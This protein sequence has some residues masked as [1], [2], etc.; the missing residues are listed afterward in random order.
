MIL[1]WFTS[2]LGNFMKCKDFGFNHNQPKNGWFGG[3]SIPKLPEWDF[4]SKTNVRISKDPTNRLWVLSW[5]FSWFEL[6]SGHS[7]TFIFMDWVYGFFGEHVLNS[8]PK[9][10]NRY[11][12][13]NKSGANNII[14]FKL[15]EK[16]S[17]IQSTVEK[18]FPGQVILFRFR[19]SRCSILGSSI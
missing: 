4:G 7:L 5:V 18:L 12:M 15:P 19:I 16:R 1:S 17:Q 13:W 9:G 8:I 6:N 3:Y 10:N 11:P 14:I 2:F